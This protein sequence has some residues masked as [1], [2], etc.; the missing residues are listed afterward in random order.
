MK[1][2]IFL[3]VG[4]VAALYTATLFWNQESDTKA[5]SSQPDIYGKYGITL[6][7]ATGKV[8]YGKNEHESSSPA[9]LAKM[10]TAL[11]LMERVKPDEEITITQNALDT[12]S[13]T[14]KI[15]LHAGEKLKRDE[16]LKLM[17]T[18]SVDQV[19]ESVAEHISGSK[20]KFVKLMNKRAKELGA[21]H[22]GFHNASGADAIGH[23]MSA[24]DLA[25]ITKE[26]IRYP[27]ILNC[28][29]HVTTTVH[30]SIQTKK[31]TNYGRKALYDDSYAIGSK[32]G[33]TVLAGYTLVT[34][35]EKD[36]RKIINVVLKS[37]KE[38][39]YKDAKKMAHYVFK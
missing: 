6:D 31:I 15:T 25:V 35:D 28:M 24:Y 19:A 29:N 30:T 11:L 18:I 16:A 4:I 38:H 22:A 3:F 10:M 1:K 32:S 17:L 20:E 39:I 37:D 5:Q 27:Q 14:S 7:A 26:A 2:R 23:N 13:G 12:E 33:R 8:L 34:I 36:G 9:S 21:K